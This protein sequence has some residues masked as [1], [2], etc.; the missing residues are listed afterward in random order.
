MQDKRVKQVVKM[1]RST[2]LLARQ[3]GAARDRRTASKVAI[4]LQPCWVT[5]F[6]SGEM[7]ATTGPVS[8]GFSLMG[9]ISGQPLM[10]D[11]VVGFAKFNLASKQR[12]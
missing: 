12:E 3:T 7:D 11:E 2:S 5:I 1:P 4:K 10:S 6:E 9:L 8:E